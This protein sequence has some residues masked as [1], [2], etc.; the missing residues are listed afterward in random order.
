LNLSL[1]DLIFR[2]ELLESFRDRKTLIFMILMPILLYPVL[3]IGFF[4]IAL[5]QAGKVRDET[6]RIAFRGPEPPAR[7]LELLEEQGAME[8]VEA[9]DLE[10]ALLNG[11][12]DAI[13]EFPPDYAAVLDAEGQIPVAVKYD[14]A[15]ERS[16]ATHYRVHTA[17]DAYREEILRARLKNRALTEEFLNPIAKKSQRAA[18]PERRAGYHLGRFLPYLILLMIINGTMYPAIDI[19]AGEKERGT[20]ECLLSSPPSPLEIV[21]AKFGVVCFFGILSAILNLASLGLTAASIF[22]IVQAQESLIHSEGLR[23][24]FILSISWD[25]MALTAV[26]LVPFTILFA[27]LLVAI[28]SFADSF[29]EAQIYIMPLFLVA[30]LPALVSALPGTDLSGIW[31][32]VPIANL[33]L[34]MKALFLEQ[35]SLKQFLEVFICSCAYAGGA[36]SL[37]VRLF[38]QEEVLFPKEQSRIFSGRLFAWRRKRA[39]TLQPKLG[40]SDALLGYAIVFPLSYFLSSLTISDSPRLS[41]SIQ[42]WVVLLGVPLALAA[43]VRVD[44]RETFRLRA[45]RPLALVGMLVALAGALCLIR[46]YVF[47]QNQWLPIPEI[48]EANFCHA[49]KEASGGSLLWLLFLAALSPAICEELFFRG[50]LLTGLR[51]RLSKWQSIII[52]ALLFGAL[53]MII[54]QFVSVTLLGILLAWLAWETGSLLPG[55]MLHFL[56]NALALAWLYVTDYGETVKAAAPASEAPEGWLKVLVDL[57]TGH[58]SWELALPAVGLLF[59][60]CW[61]VRKSK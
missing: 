5:I 19:T 10:H 6:A 29:K 20:L 4:Q 41:L 9:E 40:V 43:F 61:I 47:F 27:A 49:M 18:T 57:Q 23:E 34:L 42:Q 25:T 35:A 60:G 38:S 14:D 39:D 45:A 22:R 55:I 12:L 3:G 15:S 51:T 16:T 54:Y 50:F 2:K 11:E 37:A 7:F 21:L 53:H 56:N 17:L 24:M 59:L 1:I 31:L 8:R 13:L 33:C 52:S 30:V 28:A 46:Q 32:I 58:F 44:L 48:I 36:L 26:L